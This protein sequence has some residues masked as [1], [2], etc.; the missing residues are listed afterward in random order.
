M[1]PALDSELKRAEIN[2]RRIPGWVE[3]SVLDHGPGVPEDAVGTLF[4]PYVRLAH[5][6][7]SNGS[8][9]GLGLGI[10]RGIAEAHGGQL[11]LANHPEEGL[12]AT[13]RPSD[14]ASG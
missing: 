3:I 2:V 4:Q 11:E 10:A 1:D 8:G 7:T 9:L 5:G 13:L 14:E 12:V 6:R